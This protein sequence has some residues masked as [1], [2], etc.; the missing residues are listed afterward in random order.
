M[1]FHQA[2]SAALAAGVGSI[3]ANPSSIGG[4]VAVEAD[5]WTHFRFRSL[6]FRLIRVGT[7]TNYQTLSFVPG[8]QDTPPSTNAQNVELLSSVV[9]GGVDTR[10][11]NWCSVPAKDLAG[12]F[13]W[14]KALPGT[15]DSTEEAPGALVVTGS[16]TD[17]YL[18]ELRGVIEFKGSIATANTPEELKL[19]AQLRE[20]RRA[21]A[22]TKSKEDLLR[23]LSA[24]PCVPTGF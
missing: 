21:R 5:C 2:S 9:L 10:P 3:T 1:P 18:L 16:G 14:Y 12:P 13:P 24:P 6:R 23:V 22:V 19:M 8:I 11:T 17:V 4:R 7:V 15:A 20:L